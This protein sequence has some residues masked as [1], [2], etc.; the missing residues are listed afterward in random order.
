MGWSYIAV[1]FL[2][3]V[4]G[5]MALYEGGFSFHG[6][7]GAVSK[8]TALGIIVFGV[9]WVRFGYKRVTSETT[10]TR[11]TKYLKCVGCGQV[12]S[13]HEIENNTCPKCHKEVE[14]IE[15]FFERH[16]E[17]KD[18]GEQTIR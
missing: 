17:F 11:K 1:G 18:G 7:F 16:P 4:F 14:K 2:L 12:Y 5:S 3:I 8:L 10:L 6:V 15:G 9:I 13:F